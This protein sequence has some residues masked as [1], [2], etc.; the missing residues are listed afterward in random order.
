MADEKGMVI[1]ENALGR[2]PRHDGIASLQFPF[3]AFCM[4]LSF[5]LIPCFLSRLKCNAP[6]FKRLQE[7][8]R[9]CKWK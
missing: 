2:T 5:L 3:P 9:R 1:A 6:K 7:Q 4:H 8:Y